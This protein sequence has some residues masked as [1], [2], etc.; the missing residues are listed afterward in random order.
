MC[1]CKGTW[2]SFFPKIRLKSKW[3]HWWW[4]KNGANVLFSICKSSEG[5][6]YRIP[7]LMRLFCEKTFDGKVGGDD[8]TFWIFH[9]LG[10]RSVMTCSSQLPGNMSVD[11]KKKK[12]EKKVI[13]LLLHEMVVNCN[14]VHYCWV[15]ILPAWSWLVLGRPRCARTL[16]N[17]C[18]ASSVGRHRETTLWKA[19]LSGQIKTTVTFDVLRGWGNL[20]GLGSFSAFCCVIYYLGRKVWIIFLSFFFF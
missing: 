17:L 1:S 10:S 16:W 2:V 3:N 20:S 4:L 7:F 9:G 19:V 8:R 13:S 5:S 14:D 11:Q 6:Q 12:K 18:G 15:D